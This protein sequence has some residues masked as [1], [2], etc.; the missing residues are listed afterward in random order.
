MTDQSRL[1][2]DCTWQRPAVRERRL[3]ARKPAPA[4]ASG[5][6]RIKLHEKDDYPDYKKRE[7]VPPKMPDK[8]VSGRRDEW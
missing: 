2:R 3:G 8:P 7:D 4:K 5:A 1:S 6:N